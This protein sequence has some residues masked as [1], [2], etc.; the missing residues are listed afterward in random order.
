[1]SDEAKG[2]ALEELGPKNWAELTEAPLAVMMLGKSDCAACKTWQG[3]LEE[4][5][6]SGQAPEDVRFGK[7]LIAQP[8][9]VDFKRA[10]EWLR[11]VDV[12]PFNLI[13]QNGESKKKFAGSGLSRL[14]NRLDNVRKDS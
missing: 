7:L 2:Q 12:L 5:L 14:T 6:A 9:L 8:G 11:E 4:W 1:M 3:E 13:Y 10:N